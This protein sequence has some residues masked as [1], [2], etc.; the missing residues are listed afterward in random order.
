MGRRRGKEDKNEESGLGEMGESPSPKKLRKGEF[1]GSKSFPK[2]LR[3]S[4]SEERSGTC[5]SLSPSLF[6]KHTAILSRLF[7][8]SPRFPLPRLLPMDCFPL[9]HLLFP[10]S[11]CIRVLEQELIVGRT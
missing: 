2:G 8:L 4:G 11:L 3:L 1:K 7:Y 6:P 5:F 10:T 9:A